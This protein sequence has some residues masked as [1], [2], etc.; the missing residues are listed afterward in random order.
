VKRALVLLACLALPR[1]AAGHEVLHQVVRNQAVAV[2][3]F[4]ADG[5]VLAYTEYQLFSPTDPK[6]PF[7]KGRT[8]REG[9]VAF[10]PNVPGPWRLVLTDP[11]GHGLDL[12]VDATAPAASPAGQ[13]LPAWAFILRP[14]IGVLVVAALFLGL[15]FLLRRKA[16]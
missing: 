16:K 13:A 10:V 3:A 5:E 1:L 15:R 14:V 6:I 4:F 9:F 2:K 12:T 7:Q 8:D 11:T